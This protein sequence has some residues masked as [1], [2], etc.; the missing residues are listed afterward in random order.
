MLAVAQAAAAAV[1]TEAATATVTTACALEQ[2]RYTH[3]VP[4]RC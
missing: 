3:G 1:T 2:P 4:A